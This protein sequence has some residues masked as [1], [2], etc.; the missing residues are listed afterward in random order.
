MLSKLTTESLDGLY[1][2]SS[3]KEAFSGQ[4]DAKLLDKNIELFLNDFYSYN[5]ADTNYAKLL[6]ENRNFIS[7][8]EF[9][10]NASLEDLLQYLTFFLW[11]NNSFPG[12]FKK[13]VLDKTIFSL[14]NRLEEILKTGK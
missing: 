3:Y 9:S 13:K 1:K 7:L 5:F 6:Q 11:T 14:L 8:V 12:Y 2:I 10:K 4:T